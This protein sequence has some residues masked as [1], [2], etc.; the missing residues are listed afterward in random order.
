MGLNMRKVATGK[1]TSRP[2]RHQQPLRR[3]IP[4]EIQ[5]ILGKPPLLLHE[6]ENL[7]FTLLNRIADAI[8][9]TDLEWLWVKDF[10]D[11]SWEV[12]RLRRLKAALLNRAYLSQEMKKH[13]PVMTFDYAPL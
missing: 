11:L 2:N 1:V 10:V 3:K 9:P 13:L 4:A 7:Y 12:M 8:Q 5:K 6:D